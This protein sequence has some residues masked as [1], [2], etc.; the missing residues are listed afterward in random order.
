MRSLGIL[1]GGQLVSPP[2]IPQL[3]MPKRRDFRGAETRA[4]A[5]LG[6][7]QWLPEGH[8]VEADETGFC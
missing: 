1:R 3:S 6:V 4:L 2:P 7:L 8:W 5:S